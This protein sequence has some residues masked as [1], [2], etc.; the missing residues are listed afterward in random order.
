[1]VDATS[2]ELLAH[3]ISGCEAKVR[4]GNAKA[5]IVAEN[6]LRL[7]ITV[8]DTETVAILNCIEQLKEHMFD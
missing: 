6:V 2:A 1:M 4:D 8:I 3:F 7:Q 5:I